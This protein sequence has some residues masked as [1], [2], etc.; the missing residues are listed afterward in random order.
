MTKTNFF[1]TSPLT[2]KQLDRLAWPTH[3][4]SSAF[5]FHFVRQWG[6]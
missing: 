5:H 4:W 6:R 2:G 3:L 1:V